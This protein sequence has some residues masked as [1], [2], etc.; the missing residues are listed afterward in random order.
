VLVQTLCEAKQQGMHE[1]AAVMHK[2]LNK[3]AFLHGAVPILYPTPGRVEP[4]VTNTKQRYLFSCPDH[5]LSKVCF[6]STMRGRG[7]VN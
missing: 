6:K 4:T 1:G 5:C 3:N 7:C 2:L